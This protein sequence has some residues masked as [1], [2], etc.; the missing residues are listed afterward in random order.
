[1]LGRRLHEIVEV[2]GRAGERAHS[3]VNE[4]EQ[5]SLVRLERLGRAFLLR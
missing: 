5:F 1:L 3:S 4:R 2:C